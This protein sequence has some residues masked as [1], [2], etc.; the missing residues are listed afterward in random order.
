[1]DSPSLIHQINA[2]LQRLN[3]DLVTVSEE[4]NTGFVKVKVPRDSMRV[5][6]ENLIALLSIFT[7]STTDA[8]IRQ[9]LEKLDMTERIVEAQSNARAN[10]TR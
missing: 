6:P 7:T 8:V 2:H 5:R 10:L 4:S 9:S 3:L 1:M